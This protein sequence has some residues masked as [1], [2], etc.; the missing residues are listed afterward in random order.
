MYINNE[1]LILLH[2]DYC[3]VVWGKCGIKLVEK[4]PKSFWVVLTFTSY[5]A[6]DASQLFFFGN[7]ICEKWYTQRDIE[8]PLLGFNKSHDGTGLNTSTALLLGGLAP[9]SSVDLILLDMFTFRDVNKLDIPQSS[10]IT[11]VKVF[12]IVVLC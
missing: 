4:L 8:K 5:G 9:N 7:L 1:A 12:A 10:T 2:F 6:R 3:N 11:S